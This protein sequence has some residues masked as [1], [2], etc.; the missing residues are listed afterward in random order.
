VYRTGDATSASAHA[1]LAWFGVATSGIAW[2]GAAVAAV[3]AVIAYR[4]GATHERNIGEV[5]GGR[6]ASS[7]AE[8][9]ST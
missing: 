2:V 6:G 7:R 1:V 9:R 4:L 3:W 5:E 8:A